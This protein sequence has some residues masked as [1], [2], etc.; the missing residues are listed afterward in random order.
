[1]KSNMKGWKYLKRCLLTAMVFLMT[2]GFAAIVQAADY[3][4]NLLSQV[5]P[6]Y[7]SS[8]F[9][10]R[11]KEGEAS[12]GGETY[13]DSF[14]LNSFN[15]IDAEASFYLEGKYKSIS[16]SAGHVQAT[17]MNPRTLTVYC[18]DKV[19]WKET[20]LV[21]DLPHK[22]GTINLSGVQELKFVLSG[23]PSSF[24]TAIGNINLTNGGYTREQRM[25]PITSNLNI[26]AYSSNRYDVGNVVMGDKNFEKALK[27]NSY[28]SIEAYA[29][30]NLQNKYKT[31]SFWV[32]NEKNSVDLQTRTVT[33][34]GDGKT[35]YSKA[36]C[37]DD[38]PVYA[39][40][41]VAG[42]SQLK[43][44][45]SG[46]ASSYNVVVGGVNLT[47]EAAAVVPKDISKAS[48]TV[49]NAV[50]TGKS[51]TPK[52]T[53]TYNG[54]TLKENTDYTVSYSNNKNA[55][56]GKAVITGKGNYTG[57]ITKTFTIEK[58]AQKLTV[59]VSSKTLVVGKTAQITA[60]AKGKI[61]YTTKNKKIATVSSKGK[62]TAKAPGKVKITVKAAGGSTYKSAEKSFEIKVNPKSTKITSAKNSSKG[63]VT[64]KWN[65][66]SGITGYQI[67]YVTGSSTKTTLVKKASAKSL[68][69]KNL[70]KGKT[71]KMY[72]R[73][74][75]TVSGTKYYSS[76]SKV[77]SVKVKK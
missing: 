36:V 11:Y 71:Y 16:F 74:Y 18:D 34:T 73:T 49:A 14:M 46:T 37:A 4:S 57:S 27:F 42:V 67:K 30:F 75:K 15:S 3:S 76:W 50:Y 77:K 59:K 64:V 58:A 21:D 24:W 53:V 13:A 61:T 22:S 17:R 28:N 60:K 23:S 44:T 32:G 70:K 40:V 25:K 41:P 31:M 1:M 65:K 10:G 45:V 8:A 62:I 63:K 2:T 12:M 35:L 9:Y 20:I 5:Q 48:V 19:V 29:A 6:Y 38:A 47:G 33:V 68:T 66:V 7:T 43:I 54:T 55:G 69:I 56:T 52:V 72:V 39:S 51:L 26:E